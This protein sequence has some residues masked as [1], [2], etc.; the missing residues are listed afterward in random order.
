VG[1]TWKPQCSLASAGK[2]FFSIGALDP[3]DL[4]IGGGDGDAWRMEG[5]YGGNFNF[6]QMLFA[7]AGRTIVGIVGYPTPEAAELAIDSAGTVWCD[8]ATCAGAVPALPSAFT[9]TSLGGA[10]GAVY[11]GGAAQNLW[12]YA[13]GAA[14][15]SAVNFPTALAG[16]DVNG[17]WVAPNSE[18]DAFAVGALGAAGG[19]LHTNATLS[20]ASEA[21]PA[22]GPLYAVAGRQDAASGALDVYAAGALGTHVLHSDGTGSWTSVDIGGPAGVPRRGVFVDTDGSVVVVGDGGQIAEFY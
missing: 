1:G 22:T 10:G 15:W 14:A 9:A 2:S 21:P 13:S 7:P 11:A 16:L 18:H 17:V 3:V 6:L 20:P 8:F 12:F 4:W 5:P 19:I